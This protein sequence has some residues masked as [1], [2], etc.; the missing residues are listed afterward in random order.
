M[1]KERKIYSLQKNGSGMEKEETREQ[2]KGGDNGNK[3]I[4]I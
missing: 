2:M 4:K 3:R 1:L